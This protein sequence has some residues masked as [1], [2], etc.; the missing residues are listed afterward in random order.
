MLLLTIIL[1]YYTFTLYYKYIKMSSEFTNK[2]LKID[3]YG[4]VE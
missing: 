2:N 3:Y 4:L 1:Y